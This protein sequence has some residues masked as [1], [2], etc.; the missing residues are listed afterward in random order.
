MTLEIRAIA[1]DEYEAFIRSVHNGFGDHATPASIERWR[2]TF[3]YERSLAA[4]D[5]G[6]I[7]ATADVLPFELTV[8]GGNVVPA[9][10]V[11][12]VTVLP[13]HHRRGI[14]TEMMHRML[15]DSRDRGESAAI[16]NAS[17]SLIYGR[18]GYGIATSM[19]DV[20]IERTHA[21][22]LR[23]PA[24]DGRIRLIERHEAL[25]LLPPLYERV[26]R[27]RPGMLS[28]DAGWWQAYVGSPEA[29]PMRDGA[30]FYVVYESPNGSVE[31]IAIYALA[32]QWSEGLHTGTLTV[33]ELVAPSPEATAA[34]WQYLLGVDLIA[35]VRA[36][37]RPV[38]EP[39]RWMLADSRRLRVSRYVDELWVRPLDIPALLTARQYLAPG[40]VVLDITDAG[41]PENSGSYALEAGPDGARCQR[42]S[43][44]PDVSLDVAAL[45][46]L[47]LGGVRT[48]TLA[49][50]RRIHEL[51]PGA[52]RRVDA[53]FASDVTPWCGTSF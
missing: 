8:P 53:L 47:Y 14:L 45:G 36:V 21:Q 13:T 16:L 35:T 2:P 40:Q 28:R 1:P 30:P 3:N 5:D 29:I 4:F 52:L 7:V 44:Q 20:T 17:E 48:S 37:G 46:A 27:L 38:D 24:V 32:A 10:G 22:L 15:L 42:T 11:T 43:A 18:F 6:R 23:P 41:F 39:L 9:G 31:G 34:L 12:S 49:Q 25:E 19:I 26:R 33:R 50:A 51:R